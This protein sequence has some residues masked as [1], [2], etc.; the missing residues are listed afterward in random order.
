MAATRYNMMRDIAN[1]E[2][3]LF[4]IAGFMQDWKSSQQV[5]G[6]YVQVLKGYEEAWGPKHMPTLNTVNNLAVL[7]CDQGKINKAEEMLL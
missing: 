2:L 3:E 4:K 6:L 1:L 5:E 7:Y